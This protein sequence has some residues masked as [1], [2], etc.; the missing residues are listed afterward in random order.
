LRRVTSKDKRAEDLPQTGD[1]KEEPEASRGV[2]TGISE[3]KKYIIK[4]LHRQ[5][6]KRE[7]PVTRGRRKKKTQTEEGYN[8]ERYQWRR[9][10]SAINDALAPKGQEF[11]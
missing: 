7:L 11:L 3:G 1:A 9:G 8:K 2:R 4:V 5:R 6:R 10:G